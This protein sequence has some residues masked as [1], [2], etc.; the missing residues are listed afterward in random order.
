MKAM[1]IAT[2]IRMVLMRLNSLIFLIYRAGFFTPAMNKRIICA[3]I[4]PDAQSENR[5]QAFLYVISATSLAVQPYTWAITAAV[6]TIYEGSLRL[7]L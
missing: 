1:I 6:Y 2:I 4:V 3:V 5:R 7:P